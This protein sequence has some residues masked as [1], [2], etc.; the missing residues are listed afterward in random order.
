MTKKEQDILIAGKKLIFQ[1][2]IKKVSIEEICQ[3][4]N[5][6]KMT[7]YKYFPNK[8]ELVKKVF[9]TLYEVQID[10]YLKMMRSDIPF[11]EKMKKILE[12][13]RT[14]SAEISKEALKE[15]F[16]HSGDEFS[17]FFDEWI[18][19]SVKVAIESFAEAQ[20]QGYIRK[21]INPKI[22]LAWV[23]RMADLLSDERVLD[24][25][26]RVPDL[27]EEL[28]KMFLYGIRGER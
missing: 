8:V 21:D 20:Q 5:V 12:M 15:I 16:K 14:G 26:D 22:L 28:A 17:A 13:K 4:A 1:Y 19:R 2:G 23:E 9:D 18:E 7:F 25:Y 3:E 24:E 27:T 10:A 6:S 11:S